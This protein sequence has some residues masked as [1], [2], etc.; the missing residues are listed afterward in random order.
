MRWHSASGLG[1]IALTNHRYGPAGLLARDVLWELL[2][3]EA[4]P[5]RRTRP[6]A[7]TQAARAA[8]ESLLDAWDD[9][10]RRGA[11]RDER[12]PR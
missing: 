3:A 1:V 6:N 9:D 2:K 5:V 11:L 8:V 10:A 7:A 4:A 12:R